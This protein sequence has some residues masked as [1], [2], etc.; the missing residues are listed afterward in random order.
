MRSLTNLGL[1]LTIVLITLSGCLV[2]TPQ[3]TAAPV[4]ITRPV[5]IKEMDQPLV[6]TPGSQYSVTVEGR[7]TDSSTG[8]VIPDATILVVT[9]T[10]SYHFWGGVFEISFPAETVV[11]I[12]AEAQGIGRKPGSSRGTTR[13]MLRWICRSG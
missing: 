9:V 5:Q 3:P 7:V 12:K 2:S 8:M 13:G 11:N 10:G 4:P 1:C 6:S